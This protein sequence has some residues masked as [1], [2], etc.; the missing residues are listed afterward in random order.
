MSDDLQ[1][2]DSMKDDRGSSL[3]EE[4]KA[5]ERFVDDLAEAMGRIE[6]GDVSKTVAFRD[7]RT[8]ALFQ[9]LKQNPERLQST[10]ETLRAELGS[11]NDSKGDRSEL[12]RLLVRYS[13]QDVTPE[14]AEAEKR[15]R[16]QRVENDY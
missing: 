4:A 13:I 7:E 1:V 8:A 3:D 6:S 16:V 11:N 9:A 14:L 15:A 2:P 5:T 10:V 12:L